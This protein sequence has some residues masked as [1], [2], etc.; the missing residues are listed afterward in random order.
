MRKLFVGK[1]R[2][3]NYSSGKLFVG[4]IICR[5]NYSSGKLF[6]GGNYLS[7][8]LFVKS[9]VREISSGKLFVGEIIRQGNYSTGK[10]FVGGNYSLGKL[11]VTK[12]KFCHFPP[13]NKKKFC[14]S[15]IV[16]KLLEVELN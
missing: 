15:R 3:G 16:V 2:R 11:F 8:K 7:G 9:F 12:P 10:L 4:E 6:V 5:G 14:E 13:T 1:I